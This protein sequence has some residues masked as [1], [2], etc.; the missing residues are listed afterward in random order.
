MLALQKSLCVLSNCFV[1]VY[2]AAIRYCVCDLLYCL[3]VFWGSATVFK[4][5]LN[6]PELLI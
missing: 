1:L 4:M 3:H 2:L 6:K 5:T